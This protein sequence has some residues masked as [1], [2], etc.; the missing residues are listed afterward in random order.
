MK[1]KALKST[2]LAS[3]AS[4]LLTGCLPVENIRPVWDQAGFVDPMLN[5]VWIK[6]KSTLI[7]KAQFVQFVKDKSGYYMAQEIDDRGQPVE[8]AAH[9]YY[10]KTLQFGMNKY[11]L[12]TDLSKDDDRS[13]VIIPYKIEDGKLET[14]ALKPC[15]TSRCTN[16]LSR[17]AT[18]LTAKVR[19]VTL[20]FDPSGGVAS[21]TMKD[22]TDFDTI[23]INYVRWTPLASYQK[24]Y[25]Q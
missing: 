16:D 2:L 1:F 9:T 13:G 10:V 14:F 6:Q 20:G 3:F 21:M 22:A 12:I 17:M 11:M 4:L 7:K 23:Y 18:A 8:G 24:F 15:D 19:D 5:G 25:E